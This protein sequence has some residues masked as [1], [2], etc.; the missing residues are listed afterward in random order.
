[1]TLPNN[2][3]HKF[4]KTQY[5]NIPISPFRFLFQK[6]FKKH[7][8]HPNSITPLTHLFP[9]KSP[10]RYFLYFHY[11]FKQHYPQF[12]THQHSTQYPNYSHK[13]SISLLTHSTLFPLT[14]YRKKY[15]SLTT[16]LRATRGYNIK[17]IRYNIHHKHSK[18][19]ST[20]KHTTLSYKLRQKTLLCFN[21]CLKQ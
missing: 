10:F 8:P 11:S 16:I 15:R 13:L 18:L 3:F 9:L 4:H 19:Y 1:M 6:M 7:S 14:L 17:Y 12:N 5:P 2:K 20:P 21:R